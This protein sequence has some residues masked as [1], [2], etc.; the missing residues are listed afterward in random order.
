MMTQ[1]RRVKIR[2]LEFCLLFCIFDASSFGQSLDSLTRETAAVAFEQALQLQ[3]EKRFGEATKQLAQ[4]IRTDPEF[5]DPTRGSAWFALGRTVLALEG[6]ERAL[7]IWLTGYEKL[8]ANHLVDLNLNL[9]LVRRAVQF[10]KVEHYDLVTSAYYEILERAHPI[11]DGLIFQPILEQNVILLPEEQRDQILKDLRRNPASSYPGTVLLQFWRREDVTPATLVN[12]RLV[13]HLQRVEYALHNFSSQH[14]RGFD[15]R[16]IIFVKLGKPDVWKSSRRDYLALVEHHHHEIWYYDSIDPS[17]NY[18]FVDRGK[19]YELS[20]LSY[21]NEYDREKKDPDISTNVLSAVEEIPVMVRTARFL[22]NDGATRLEMY[23]GVRKANLMVRELEPL[24]PHDTLTVKLLTT[25]EDLN[26]WPLNTS[27]ETVSSFTGNDALN[28]EVMTFWTATQTREDSFFVSC[29]LE[30]WLKSFGTEFQQ[31]ANSSLRTAW[32]ENYSRSEKLLRLSPLRSHLQQALRL[33]K[34]PLLMSDLQISDHVVLD[35]PTPTI[36][37][38]KIF[39]APF[40]SADVNRSTLLYVY[41]EIYGLT[42]APETNYRITYEAE[43]TKPKR[44]FF[45]AVKSL[46]GAGPHGKVRLESDYSGKIAHP[47]EW[48]ALDLKA[49]SPGEARITIS[50]QDLHSQV[51]AK[52]SVNFNLL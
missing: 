50:V 6:H 44:R 23:F 2:A 1:T 8:Q 20:F 52:R 9:E 37:K 42:L 17:L 27:Q 18:L 12:E 31:Q 15:D 28:N 25:V 22:E 3:R 13:E 30:T 19:G 36:N 14:P 40:S 48:I 21:E 38:G 26:L 10:E 34:N 45:G 32:R 47:R 24:L 49:L 33:E 11:D 46:F 43:V 39:I 51:M 7:L 16:G 5:I 35:S 29:Q 4:L 41:F